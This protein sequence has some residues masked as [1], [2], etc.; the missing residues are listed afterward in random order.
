MGEEFEIVSKNLAATIKRRR[1][2]L[3]FSQ[4]KFADEI[5]VDRTYMSKIE[6]SIGNPSL[7]KLVLIANGLGCSITDLFQE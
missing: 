5:K 7:Q 3:G 6:R 2:E 4:E 1:K